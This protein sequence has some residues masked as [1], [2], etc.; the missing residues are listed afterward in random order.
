MATPTSLFLRQLNK[1]SE[2]S[3]LV[4]ADPAFASRVVRSHFRSLRGMLIAIMPAVALLTAMTTCSL[5]QDQGFV[6]FWLPQTLACC[7]TGLV[8]WWS[9][10]IHRR[11]ILKT[12]RSSEE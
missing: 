9:Y 1:T 4:Q 12:L 10:R 6:L 7:I 11:L 5:L 2:G 8:A 3:R